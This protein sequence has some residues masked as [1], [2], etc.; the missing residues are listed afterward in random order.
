[1][2]KHVKALVI[3]E[4]KLLM[5]RIINQNNIQRGLVF[6]YSTKYQ[7]PVSNIGVVSAITRLIIIQRK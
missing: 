2:D 5:D 1:M 7:N 6:I 4:C 3:S